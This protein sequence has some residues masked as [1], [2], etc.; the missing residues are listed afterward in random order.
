MKTKLK[1]KTKIIHLSF[2]Y[3]KKKKKKEKESVYGKKFSLNL[4][5]YNLIFASQNYCTI[6]LKFNLKIKFD[7]LN[8]INTVGFGNTNVMDLMRII[9]DFK[10]FCKTQF[11]IK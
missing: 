6:C 5:C 1:N 8:F 3:K 10:I 9:K 4:T 7:T 2:V 11:C